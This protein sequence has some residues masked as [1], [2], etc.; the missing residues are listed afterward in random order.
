MQELTKISLKY[1][2]RINIL[3]PGL[4]DLTG[5]LKKND[6]MDRKILN[7]YSGSRLLKIFMMPGLKKDTKIFYPQKKKLVWWQDNNHPN[8]YGSKIAAEEIIKVLKTLKIK[9]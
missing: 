6:D 7:G 3:L 8:K 1:N 4:F 5:N 9:F 2:K